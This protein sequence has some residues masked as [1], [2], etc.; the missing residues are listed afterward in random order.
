VRREVRECSPVTTAD[1]YSISAV[2]SSTHRLRPTAGK[3]GEEVS[4]RCCRT[5]RAVP[6]RGSHRQGSRAEGKKKRKG[7]VTQRLHDAGD[8]RIS[9]IRP[10]C[11]GRRKEKEGRL[12][13]KSTFFTYDAQWKGKRRKGGKKEGGV[14]SIRHIA[15]FLCRTDY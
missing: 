5:C 12:H 11:G 4:R 13:L 9:F 8:S 7:I 14:L 6:Y 2:Y 10:G 3:K 1:S 15:V